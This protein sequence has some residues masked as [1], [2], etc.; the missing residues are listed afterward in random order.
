LRD[1][2]EEERFH[3]RLAAAAKDWWVEE[4]SLWGPTEL[5]HDRNSGSALFPSFR[6]Y[7]RDYASGCCAAN[8]VTSASGLSQIQTGGPAEIVLLSAVPNHS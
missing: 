1:W 3:R 7:S 6:G 4:G 5:E 2:R 8:I